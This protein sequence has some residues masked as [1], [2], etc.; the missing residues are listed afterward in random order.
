[1]YCGNVVLYAAKA[2]TAKKMIENTDCSEPNI[3]TISEIL[4]QCVFFLHSFHPHVIG[5]GIKAACVCFYFGAS[6]ANFDHTNA[7]PY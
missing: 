5:A 1:M 2:I 4:G 3:D 7:I 6:I